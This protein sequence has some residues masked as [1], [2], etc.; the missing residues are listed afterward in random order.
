ML[1]KV[2]ANM[3]VL[4]QKLRNYHWNMTGKGFM[5][6]HIA[7][8]KEY[9]ALADE[10][11]EVA[12]LVR[13]KGGKPISTLKEFLDH[14]TLVEGDKEKSMDDMLA[15]IIAD[16]K[17]LIAQLK[18]EFN[19]DVKTEDVL[20]GILARLEKSVWLLSSSQ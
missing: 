5:A 13:I 9:E 12:E 2:I 8:E 11:D 18:D 17:T 20:T 16:F 14:A 7:F 6:M 19:G 1:E 10:I 3:A 4:Y 15:E